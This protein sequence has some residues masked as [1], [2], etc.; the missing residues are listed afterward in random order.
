MAQSSGKRQAAKKLLSAFDT[1][2]Y[3]P[4]TFAIT[5]EL[6]EKVALLAEQTGK[7]VA[8]VVSLLL[9]LGMK[10]HEEM[11]EI[12]KKTVSQTFEKEFSSYL[13]RLFLPLLG[14]HGKKNVSN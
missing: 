3:S 1:G 2:T 14:E 11:V 4:I 7:N 9:E 5:P 8:E 12:A 6:Y 10:N 13:L